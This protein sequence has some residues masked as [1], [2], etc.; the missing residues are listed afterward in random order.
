MTDMKGKVVLSKNAMEEIL[1]LAVL[2]VYGVTGLAPVTFAERF[3][4]ALSIPST[5]KGV[6]AQVRKD[7]TIEATVHVR[8]QYGLRVSE[9]A[10]TIASQVRYV[11]CTM[12]GIS[13]ER[14]ELNVVV[15]SIRVE[16]ENE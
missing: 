9:V 3:T 16:H 4:R 6:D 12:T 14:V 2:N 15:W 10:R 13:Q 8:L 7:G 5:P 1:R 11:F